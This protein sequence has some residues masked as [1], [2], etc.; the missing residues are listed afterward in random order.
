MKEL[1]LI[2]SVNPGFIYY[3][4]EK[5]YVEKAAEKNDIF[6]FKSM[7]ENGLTIITNSDFGLIPPDPMKAIYFAVTRKTR[8]GRVVVREQAVSVEQAI[9]QYTI[10][11]AYAGYEENIKGTL[12]IGK[13]ADMVV[14]SEDPTSVNAED[15]DKIEVLKTIVAG[16]IIYDRD[17]S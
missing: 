14:L 2:A 10:N 13:V 8:Q 1:G 15:L 11:A 17:G 12:E 9:R 3:F 5:D 7:Q 4:G 6:P 16:K